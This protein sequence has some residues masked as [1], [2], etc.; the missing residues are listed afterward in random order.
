[1]SYVP[2]LDN[3][4]YEDEMDAYYDPESGNYYTSDADGNIYKVGEDS[5]CN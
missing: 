5:P 2:D 4:Y 1:M 3:C